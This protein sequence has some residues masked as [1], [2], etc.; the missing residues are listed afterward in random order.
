METSRRRGAAQDA[1]L[2]ALISAL[3][4]LDNSEYRRLYKEAVWQRLAG[5]PESKLVQAALH[6]LYTR[7]N[8][9]V[10]AK[11]VRWGCLTERSVFGGV[12]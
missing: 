12:Q 8:G 1:Y 7:I 11:K 4:V 9:R 10:A 3:Q 5:R 6:L 2:P